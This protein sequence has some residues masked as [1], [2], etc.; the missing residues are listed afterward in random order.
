M[1]QS[2]STNRGRSSERLSGRS[3]AVVCSRTSGRH[4]VSASRKPR[5]AGLTS[6]L[7]RTVKLQGEVAVGVVVIAESHT[8]VVGETIKVWSHRAL[9][10]YHLALSLAVDVVAAYL[11]TSSLGGFTLAVLGLNLCHTENLQTNETKNTATTDG[12]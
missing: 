7:K 5:A 11:S 8:F 9:Q 6:T 1:R 2:D 12:L 3:R 4:T 10:S